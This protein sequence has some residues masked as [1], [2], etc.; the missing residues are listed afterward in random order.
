M[1]VSFKKT[2]AGAVLAGL[3]SASFAYG[4]RRLGGQQSLVHR[5][6]MSRSTKRMAQKSMLKW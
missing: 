2:V 5:R 3:S 6:R 4:E 1:K